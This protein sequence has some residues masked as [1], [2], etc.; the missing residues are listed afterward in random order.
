MTELWLDQAAAPLMINSFF[1]GLGSILAPFIARPFLS[2]ANTSQ[3]H[4][5]QL[6]C[7]AGHHS[8]TTTSTS[9]GDDSSREESP[10][11]RI[12]IPYAIIGIAIIACCLGHLFFVFKG[13]PKSWPPR[14]QSEPFWRLIHI[15]SCSDPATP[16]KACLLL[17][18]GTYFAL[19]FGAQVTFHSY[20]SLVSVCSDLEFSTQKAATATSLFF[21]MYT[22]ARLLGALCA[23]FISVNKIIVVAMA[24]IVLSMLC[25]CIW[26]LQHEY[27]YWPTLSLTALCTSLFFPSGLA[28]CNLNTEMTS[29]ASMVLIVGCGLGQIICSYI[30]GLVVRVF[31]I[32]AVVWVPLISYSLLP[33]VFVGMLIL[34]HYSHKHSQAINIE[35]K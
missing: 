20:L 5:L 16:Y 27:I 10:F 18:A 35:V 29:L 22:S 9:H 19:F 1:D 4:N 8:N 24:V 23:R 33:L 11:C 28:W 6:Y 15:T 31:S 30:A 34:S 21:I 25:L 32:P 3:H 7:S 12:E 17:L 14:P 26:G 13:V 2:Q